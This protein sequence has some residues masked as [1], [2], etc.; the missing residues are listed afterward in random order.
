VYIGSSWGFTGSAVSGG[1]CG[2][3]TLRDG[4]KIVKSARVYTYTEYTVLYPL[5]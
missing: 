3:S 2:Y 5:K 4:E 1:V